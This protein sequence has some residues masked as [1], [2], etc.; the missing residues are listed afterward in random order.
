M[1][2][3]L[4]APKDY[5]FVTQVGY[6]VPLGDYVFEVTARDSLDPSRGDS[7][8]IPITIRRFA[9]KPSMS[10]LEL[11]SS[12]T[13]SK[14]DK[15]NLFYKNGYLVVPNPSLVFGSDGN[16]VV[17]RYSELYDLDPHMTYQVRVKLIDGTGKIVREG[18]ARK[19][20]G[21]E[22]ALELGSLAI[23]A[24]PSGKYKFQLA[25]ADSTSRMLASIEKDVFLFNPQMKTGQYATSSASTAD[26]AGLTGDELAEEFKTLQY[27]ATDEE[28]RN[29]A[30]ITSTEGRRQFL[31]QLWAQVNAGREGR[32]P[33]SRGEYL[34]RVQKADQRFHGQGQKGWK[35]DRGRV[36]LLYGEPDDIER[37]P[38][39]VNS[40]PYEIWHYYHIE[41]GV[42]FDFVDRSG[43]GDYILV[44]ST[45][46]GEIQD[47]QWQRF[48]Q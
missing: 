24:I 4:K 17:L 6:E 34:Q 29:F 30:K 12:V 14:E 38:N 48:L 21:V 19:T 1:S 15:T 23:T 22:N 2:D 18:L 13:E 33:V 7:L 42:E 9:T 16:P 8:T 41:S 25:L 40:K 39:I 43:F 47:D 35:S 46:R 32:P 20:Y 26:L 3:T 11:C 37:F 45:K 27:Y 28:I 44:N 5:S 36:L 10:D 31:S